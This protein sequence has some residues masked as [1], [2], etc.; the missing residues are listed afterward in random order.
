M[1]IFF[2]STQKLLN[3]AFLNA[4]SNALRLRYYLE[5]V[6]QLEIL[7]I[8]GTALYE[9]IC[10]KIALDNTLTSNTNYKTLLISYIQPC[11]EHYIMARVSDELTTDPNANKIMQGKAAAF[12]RTNIAEWQR[13]TYKY[14][15][16]ALHFANRLS[17]YLKDNRENYPLYNANCDSEGGISPKNSFYVSNLF[18]D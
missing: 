13:L 7:P 6:Q 2:I 16:E 14:K 8:L 10:D 1:A 9:D 15:A 11:M 4:N 12:F 18:L 5:V 17:A 3:N